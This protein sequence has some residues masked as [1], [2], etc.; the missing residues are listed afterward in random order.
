MVPVLGTQKEHHFRHK[1]TGERPC[2]RET[3]LHRLAKRI[4]ADGFSAAV[5]EGRPYWL[6]CELPQLC[7]HW[8][9]QFGFICERLPGARRYD[10][11]RHFDQVRL[12]AAIDGFVADVLLSSSKSDKKLLIEIAVSHPC[13]QEK[14]ASGLRI[15]ELQVTCEDDLSSLSGGLD[16][17][18]LAPL[19]YNFKSLVPREIS[20]GGGCERE[21]SAFLVYQSGKSRIETGKPAFVAAAMRGPGVARARV[22][23]RAPH[24]IITPYIAGG[25]YKI[26]AEKALRAGAPIKCCVLCRHAG[27]RTVGKRVFCKIRRQEVGMNE[28][29]TCKAYEVQ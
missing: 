26:E 23:E 22:I 29:T 4:V 15:L 21:V 9:D 7:R 11:T 3:Y 12:E 28:A 6:T 1:H 19:A 16:R 2:S 24:G 20:C 27:F 10:L 17:A 8:E 5:R 18:T 25:G 14:I 13:T